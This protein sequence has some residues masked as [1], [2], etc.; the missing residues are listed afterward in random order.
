MKRAERGA[1]LF[2]DHDEKTGCWRRTLIYR[3]KSAHP[4]P[5]AAHR[6]LASLFETDRPC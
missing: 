1:T 2:R 3:D 6:G 4:D 5:A